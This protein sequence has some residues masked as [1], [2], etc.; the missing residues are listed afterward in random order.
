M[1]LQ[2]GLCSIRLVAFFW[3]FIFILLNNN[4]NDNR[5]INKKT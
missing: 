5:D 4:K 2:I 3:L 1:N